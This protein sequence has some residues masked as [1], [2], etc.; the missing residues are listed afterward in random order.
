MRT[1][2]EAPITNVARGLDNWAAASGDFFFM[3]KPITYATAAEKPDEIAKLIGYF[4]A[5]HS[6][7]QQ[8]VRNDHGHLSCSFHHTFSRR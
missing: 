4:L 3:P 8:R 7:S 6:A 1:A 5:A 2:I